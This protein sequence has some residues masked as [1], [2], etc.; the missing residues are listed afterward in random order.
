MRSRMRTTLA[1]TLTTLL[2]AAVA[3]CDREGGEVPLSDED[4]SPVTEIEGEVTSTTHLEHLE[5][6]YRD[7]QRLLAD[8]GK[9]Y[10]AGWNKS[11]DEAKEKV[12]ELIAIHVRGV[13][14]QLANEEGTVRTRARLAEVIANQ[15][16]VATE[17]VMGDIGRV[18]SQSALPFPGEE[19]TE[20]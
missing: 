12:D 3:G 17:E 20:R 2:L 13:F 11:L 9:A 6:L 19:K 15:A 5:S 16:N 14:F 10:A 7:R 18:D 4:L 8:G 1:A